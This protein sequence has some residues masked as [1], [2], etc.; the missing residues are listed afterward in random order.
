MLFLCHRFFQVPISSI[1]SRVEVNKVILNFR[2]LFLTNALVFYQQVHPLL[3][4]V[5]AIFVLLMNFMYRS[6]QV[7]EMFAKAGLADVLHKLWAWIALHKSVLISGLKLIATFT[8]DCPDG[9]LLIT[10]CLFL[11][12]ENFVWIFCSETLINNNFI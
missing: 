10:I 4:E 9:Q 11:A 6:V 2:S 5:N 3:H 8:T 1:N 7:K 12:F